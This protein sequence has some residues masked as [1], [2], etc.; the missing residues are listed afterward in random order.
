[1]AGLLEY[2]GPDI[3]AKIDQFNKKGGLAGLLGMQSVNE[4]MIAND[5]K[6]EA[7]AQSGAPLAEQWKVGLDNPMANFMGPENLALKVGIAA[8][9]A[10]RGAKTADV[11]KLSMA[12]KLAS[13]GANRDEIWSKTGWFEG[14]DNKWRFEIPDNG[15]MYRGASAA[16]SS[17]A[18]DMIHHPELFDAYPDAVSGTRVRE[19]VGDGG[20]YNDAGV[21][22][23]RVG[24]GTP[25]TSSTAIHELQHAI[26]SQE[27]FARGGNL[28]DAVSYLLK[29][30]N[31]E[32]NKISSAMESRKAELGLQ[33]YRPRTT[34]AKML[35]LQQK[36]DLLQSTN[37][38][39]DQ[40]S[41]AW[42]KRLAGEAEA[43]NVQ[44]RMNLTP[45]QRAAQPPWATLDVPEAD[46]IVRHR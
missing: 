45:E 25:S 16:E 2:Y 17:A 12:Q 33:G 38:A 13:A 19:F 18:K 35:D 31:D 26:Q 21:G 40:A 41:Y 3:M 37:P 43:R 6:A 5:D 42:Y 8:M 24:T 36:Y 9:F 44:T 28:G 30:R 20:S 14:P 10:G 32:L 29:S 11:V 15:A 4:Q 27:G 23:I 1:M 39:T 7:L 46:L 34:D 22:E